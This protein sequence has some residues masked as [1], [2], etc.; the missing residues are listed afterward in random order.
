MSLFLSRLVLDPRSRKVQRDLADCHRAHRRVMSAFAD[1]EGLPRKELGILFRI[2]NRS[3]T[4]TML[5][6]SSMHPEWDRLPEGYLAA[7][8]LEFEGSSVAVKALDSALESLVARKTLRF[9]L[10]A[11]P[12][13]RIDT[14]SGPDGIRRHGKRVPLR[15]VEARQAW[16]ARRAGPA[17]FELLEVTSHVPQVVE[18]SMERVSGW[19]PSRDES[20]GAQRITLEGVTFDGRL[21]VRDAERLR[22]AVAEGIGPGKA[23]GFGLLSL[24]PD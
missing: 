2:E 23:Y 12:T 5:V 13:R 9:R 11:N 4:V 7:D 20:E 18:S 10:R 15:Q 3:D 16:M 24:A 19:R 14:K 17:G 8:W 22:A 21:R 1:C 6:Q